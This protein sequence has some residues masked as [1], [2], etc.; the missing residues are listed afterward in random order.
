MFISC[1]RNGH[2]TATNHLSGNDLTD[3]WLRQGCAGSGQGT[4]LMARNAGLISV[5]QNLKTE[6]NF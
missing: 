2:W 5:E 3:D 6:A 1:Q 4:C